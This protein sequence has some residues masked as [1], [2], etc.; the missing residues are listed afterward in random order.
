MNGRDLGR[1]LSRVPVL[2]GIVGFLRMFREV[3][4]TIGWTDPGYHS[5]RSSGERLEEARRV[6]AIG[7]SAPTGSESHRNAE[8]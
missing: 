6:G 4:D 5:V 2:G 1:K 3:Y 7:D 8:Q